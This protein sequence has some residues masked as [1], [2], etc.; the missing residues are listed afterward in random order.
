MKIGALKINSQK[1]IWS[2]IHNM[3]TPYHMGQLQKIWN[4]QVCFH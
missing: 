4:D 3:L 2:N 1:C